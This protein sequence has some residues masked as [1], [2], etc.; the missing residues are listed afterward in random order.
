M[1]RKSEAARLKKIWKERAGS[2]DLTYA[3]A[4]K[5]MGFGENYSAVS[6]MINGRNVINLDRGLQFSEILG[7]SLGDF[8]PRLNSKLAILKDND[9]VSDQEMSGDVGWLV[10]VEFVV[11][12]KILSGEQRTSK[13]IFWAGKHSKSTYA[14]EVNS[15]ANSPAL[16]NKSVAIVDCGAT[17]VAGKMVCLLRSGKISYARYCGDGVAELVNPSFPDRVFKINE[18][19]IIGSVIGHQVSD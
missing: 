6:H 1:D 5:V 9:R 4:A 19:K 18:N 10:G 16:P 8:S 15:E 13:N 11:A 12:K 7:C 14:L 3:K 2:L 17:P